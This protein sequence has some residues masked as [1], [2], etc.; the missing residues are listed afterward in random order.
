MAWFQNISVNPKD[1]TDLKDLIPLS[2]DQDE[3]FQRFVNLKKVKNGD[4]VAFIGEG[5]EVGLAG[6]GCDPEYQEYG[7]ANSQ[8]RW[9]LGDWQIPLKICY[10]SLHGT[11][12]EYTLKN[13]TDIADLTGTE[14]M[15]YILRPAL[16]KQMKRMIWR[17]GWFGDT[18]AKKQADGGMLTDS[19]ALKKELFTTCD[20]LF[21]RIFAQCVA[22]S[23]QLTTIA[24]NSEATFA[25]QRAAMLQEGV[26]SNLLDMML[27]DADSRITS[28]PGAV[29]LMTKAMADCLTYDVKNRYKVIMPWQTVF[30]GLDMTEYNGVK[31]ARVSI[32]D[33][34]IQAYEHIEAEASGN[35]PA[36]NKPNKPFRMVYANTNTQLQVATESGGLLEDLD[37]WFDKKERRNYIYATGKIGTQ[38]LEN[39]MFHAAY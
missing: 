3:E 18:A 17:F 31:I 11:I 1:V 14:F 34:M 25:A 12:A 27:M 7:V 37:I 2:I 16:E 20:G 36:Q 19:E 33:R 21:K 30:Q 28:D 15:T 38:I 22:N 23:K 4:P 26:A 13:G 24:A 32:W 39:D 6:S 35:T 8:K 5:D 10:E 9:T 29:I